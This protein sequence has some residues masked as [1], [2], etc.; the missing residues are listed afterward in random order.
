MYLGVEKA[1]HGYGAAHALVGRLREHAGARAAGLYG[2]WQNRLLPF[3]AEVFPEGALTG[4]TTL[5]SG[6]PAFNFIYREPVSQHAEPAAV[7][8][9]GR[10]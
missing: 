9:R 1:R 7:R 5:V 2:N 8:Y 3:Y 6:G 4:T 10:C